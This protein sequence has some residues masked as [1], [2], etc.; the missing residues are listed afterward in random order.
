MLDALFTKSWDE[1]LLRRTERETE[2]NLTKF[3]DAMLKETATLK[4]VDDLDDEEMLDANLEALIA[5]EVAAGIKPMLEELNQLKNTSAKNVPGGAKA[6][7]PP[8]RLHR[9][10]E[11]KWSKQTQNGKEKTTKRTAQ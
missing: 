11:E 4:I 10:Q 1:F 3:V 6:T 2:L 9:Q 5:R 8:K 7:G